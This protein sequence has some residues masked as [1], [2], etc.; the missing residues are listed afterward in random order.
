M[1]NTDALYKQL[2]AAGAE[3]VIQAIISKQNGNSPVTY[4]KNRIAA[5]KVSASMFGDKPAT[6]G[7][8]IAKKLNLVLLNPGNIP[9]T[10]KIKMEYKLVDR[11]SGQE[12]SW[13]PKGTFYIDT[14]QQNTYSRLSIEAYDA[15]L[16]ASQQ[17]YTNDGDQGMW[18]RTDH[19]AI[20][21]EI[22]VRIGVTVDPRTYEIVNQNFEIGYPGYGEDAYTCRD[23]LGFI[24]AMYG[25]NWVITDEDKLRLIVLGDIPEDTNLLINEDGDYITMGG[26]RIIVS[27]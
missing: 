22:A 8:C 13:Y 24:G 11:A 26:D 2:L 25:G 12:S 4:G 9:R 17:Y 18:P 27:R 21:E 10:A 19:M 20:V 15:M 23:V 1:Q 6:V 14:R 5:A 7:N 3:K 16:K